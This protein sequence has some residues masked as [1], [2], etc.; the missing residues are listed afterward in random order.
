MGSRWSFSW[1]GT[2]YGYEGALMG[3][4]RGW[5][6]L[7]M[8]F[9]AGAGAGMMGGDPC[10]LLNRPGVHRGPLFRGASLGNYPIRGP[11]PFLHSIGAVQ[12][13][14][15][16]DGNRHGKR[17]SGEHIAG[18]QRRYGVGAIFNDSSHGLK[19]EARRSASGPGVSMA[20]FYSLP[21]VGY[22]SIAS[23]GASQSGRGLGIFPA[24]HAGPG[25]WSCTIMDWTGQRFASSDPCVIAGA[26]QF[27]SPRFQTESTALSNPST[28]PPRF[29]PNKKESVCL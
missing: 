18:W 1:D 4:F 10:W 8:A 2:G 12:L 23:R 19:K 29:N 21:K 13:P 26:S 20:I 16:I 28:T 9:C 7:L 25:L 22:H 24:C 17:E 14:L 5:L 15:V 27:A 11:G 3:L 6:V